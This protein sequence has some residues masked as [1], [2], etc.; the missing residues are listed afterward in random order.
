MCF[1]FCFCWYYIVTEPAY[2]IYVDLNNVLEGPI[3]KYVDVV[4]FCEV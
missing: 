4:L 2:F 1:G 3:C